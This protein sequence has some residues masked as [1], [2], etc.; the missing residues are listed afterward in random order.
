M[1]QN[2]TAT[3]SKQYNKGHCTSKRPLKLRAGLGQIIL[4]LFWLDQ[5]KSALIHLIYQTDMLQI[6]GA[7]LVEPTEGMGGSRFVLASRASSD[8][9]ARMRELARQAFDRWQ[10]PGHPGWAVT[11]ADSDVLLG[12]LEQSQVLCCAV[13]CWAGLGWAGLGWAGLCCA[14]LQLGL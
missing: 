13:L 2:N 8:Q 4:P 10:Q 12:K 7:V 1:T 14:V 9:L 3:E 5:S 6:D 11:Q